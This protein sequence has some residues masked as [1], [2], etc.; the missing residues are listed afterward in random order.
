MMMTTMSSNNHSERER[1][2]KKREDVCVYVCVSK[3]IEEEGD[4]GDY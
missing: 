3:E 2:S 1:E 4:G